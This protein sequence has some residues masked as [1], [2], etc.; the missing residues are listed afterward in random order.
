MRSDPSACLPEGAT[1]WQKTRRVRHEDRDHILLKGIH[2]AGPRAWIEVV[3]L[4]L[5]TENVEQWSEST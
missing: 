2:R 1:V 4:T 5:G 3:D